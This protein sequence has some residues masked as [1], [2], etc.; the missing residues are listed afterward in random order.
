MSEAVTLTSCRCDDSSGTQTSVA[1][2]DRTAADD[3][4]DDDDDDGDD[5]DD[6]DD[7]DAE[8]EDESGGISELLTASF[9]RC[10]EGFA[11]GGD[12]GLV[13][14]VLCTNSKITASP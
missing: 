9:D 3:D 8:D 4:D 13:G 12:V 10:G 11:E 5:D 7:D 14:F 2:V 6:D 1:D